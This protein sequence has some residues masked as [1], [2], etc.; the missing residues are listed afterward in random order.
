MTGFSDLTD[1]GFQDK[2]RVADLP[3]N[4]VALVFVCRS[5]EERIKLYVKLRDR[6]RSG[7]IRML[8]ETTRVK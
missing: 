4:E 5:P 3:G 1:E 2:M 8:I 7:K 6:L